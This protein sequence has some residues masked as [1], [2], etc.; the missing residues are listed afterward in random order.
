[1]RQWGKLI[2]AMEVIAIK[3]C[4]LP[5]LVFYNANALVLQCFNESDE[6]RELVV[7]RRTYYR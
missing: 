4:N 2:E 7:I 5:I 6:K 1:M 3:S